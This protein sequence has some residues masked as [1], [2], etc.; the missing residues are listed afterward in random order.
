MIPF[1]TEAGQVTLLVPRIVV[2]LIF[3]LLIP[4]LQPFFFI[5]HHFN[6]FLGNTLSFPSKHQGSLDTGFIPVIFRIS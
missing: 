5:F 6:I 3:R 4:I 1:Q 2:V